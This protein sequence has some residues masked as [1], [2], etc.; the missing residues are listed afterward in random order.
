MQDLSWLLTN[1]I[2]IQNPLPLLAWIAAWRGSGTAASCLRNVAAESRSALAGDGDGQGPSCRLLC[3]HTH[4]RSG[5]NPADDHPPTTLSSITVF[6]CSSPSSDRRSARVAR[7]SSRLRP[8]CKS[9]ARERNALLGER[10]AVARNFSE[11]LTFASARF[12]SRPGQKPRS[13]CARTARSVPD[14][15]SMAA[16]LLLAPNRPALNL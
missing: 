8:T 6:A 12:R 9:P 13:I 16:K 2:K 3:A 4:R 14:F 1:Q 10:M 5:R 7:Q 11:F 15:R